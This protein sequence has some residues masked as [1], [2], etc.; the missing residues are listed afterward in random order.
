MLV[1]AAATVTRILG[2]RPGAQELEV[3][4]A[5]GAARAISYTHLLRPLVPGDQVLINTTAVDLGLGTGGVHFVIGL[6]PEQPGDRPG[7]G[8]GHTVKL[9][10]TPLQFACLAAE[11]PASPHHD[12]LREANSLQGCPVVACGLHSM[13]APAAAG[14]RAAAAR[15]RVVYVMTDAA[16]LPAA[17]S[18]LA[19]ELRQAELLAGVVTCGQAFGGDLEAVNLYSG[20]LAGKWALGADV[21]VAGQGPGSVGTGTDWGCSA[22]DAA[23]VINAA[24]ALDGQP[25]A[26]PRLGWGDPRPRHQGLSRHS[27][28]ALGRAALAR[29]TVVL[30]H[31]EPARAAQVARQLGEAGIEARHKVVR[32][33]GRP[34]LEALAAAGIAPTTMGRGLE[35]EPEFFQAA[36]AAG[37]FAAELVLEAGR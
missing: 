5:Q 19:A 34:G 2:E 8:P 1:T 16:A 6:R 20:L 27:A 11:E 3:A 22:L 31:L 28:V 36:A 18:R 12:L 21:L 9:R 25:V 32:V 24:A 26:V 35:Q 23:A 4:T 14:V 10:Y 17:L 15:L 33:D 30:P 29:A 37:R 7:P 13:L